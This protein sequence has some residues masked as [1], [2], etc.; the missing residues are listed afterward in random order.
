M[1]IQKGVKKEEEDNDH[2]SEHGCDNLR[3]LQSN[4]GKASVLPQ[5]TGVSKKGVK[6]E[7][8]IF[9]G[10]K[11]GMFLFISICSRNSFHTFQ[12]L[13]LIPNQGRVTRIRRTLQRC[14]FASSTLRSSQPESP[15]P[16]DLRQRG[17]V[18]TNSP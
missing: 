8:N 5:Y 4:F 11:F 12:W 13:C 18:R 7:S 14:T 15:P 3:R 1:Y 6:V 2:E 17:N 10:M 9:E 16:K